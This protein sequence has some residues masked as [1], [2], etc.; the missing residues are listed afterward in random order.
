MGITNRL[1]QK[2]IQFFDHYRFKESYRKSINKTALED[3]MPWI[4]FQAFR[5]L[6]KIMK[7]EMHVFEFGMGGST[8]FFAQNVEKIVSIEHNPAWFEKVNALLSNKGLANYENQVI[9]PVPIADYDQKTHTNPTDY[10]S[11][12]MPDCRHYSFEKYA[13]SIEAYPDESFD[14]ILVDG[15]SRN[16]CVMHAISKLKK[17]GFLILD[18]A[19][20]AD[21]AYAHQTLDAL[22]W[23]STH[24]WGLGPYTHTS[25]R[26]W[27]TSFWQRNF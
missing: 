8:L 21:Y 14:M 23:K 27:Q 12:Y 17:N 19:E 1:N 15:R 10:V 18:N 11:Y 22:H 25:T 4:N 24:F 3:E 9:L 16:A 26:F 20:R 6:Q 7:P 13:Q 2:I 5:F